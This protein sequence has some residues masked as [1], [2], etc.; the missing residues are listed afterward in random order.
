MPFLKKVALVEDLANHEFLQ[1]YAFTREDGADGTTELKPAEADKWEMFRDRLKNKNAHP[2]VLNRSVIESAAASQP[3]NRRACA[4]ST[5]WLPAY[6]AFVLPSRSIGS[7]AAHICGVANTVVPPA[8]LRP[9]GKSAIWLKSVGVVAAQS[10]GMMLTISCACAAPLLRMANEQSFGI[11]LS[12]KTGGGKTTATLAGASVFSVGELDHLLSWNST[13]AGLEPALRA[14]NDCLLV[15]DDLNKM[16]SASDKEKYRSARDFAYNLSTGSTK[17]RSRVFDDGPQNGG[18][19]RII[20]LTSAETTIADLAASCGEQ[21]TGGERRRLIDVPV[22]FDGLGHIFDRAKKAEKLTHT[23]LATMFSSIHAACSRNHGHIYTKYIKFLIRCR[24]DLRN[25]IGHHVK[26]FTAKHAKQTNI[27]EAD[28]IRKFGLIYA[29]GALAIEGAGLPWTQRALLDALSKGCNAALESL[30]SEERT[31]QAGWQL[32]L[33]RLK[34]LPQKRKIKRSEYS[35]IDGY[36]EPKPGRYRCVIKNDKFNRMF[37]NAL[38]RKMVMDELARRGWITLSRSQE[39]QGQFIWPD[40]VRRRS[41]EINWG[42][43]T[44][45]P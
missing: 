19:Y 21:R 23:E 13:L 3:E 7:G 20:S 5:G 26:R 42:R 27:L 33:A 45:S 22:Y 24:S 40:G 44:S 18:Q 28:I 2:S 15:V 6:R 39:N 43:R 38:Q 32:L 41:L 34:S 9:R 10:S 1:Q 25:M 16:P 17:R 36:V 31:R 29:G 4:A 14:H 8:H 37:S 30:P 12:G 35:S 11:C